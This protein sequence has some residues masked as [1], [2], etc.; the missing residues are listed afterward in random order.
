M[1]QA[2]RPVKIGIMQDDS[3]DQTEDAVE[4]AQF[5]RLSVNQCPALR[6]EQIDA[7]SVQREDH[8][9][10]DRIPH[11][12]PDRGRA[13]HTW[14]NFT[15]PEG[16]ALPAIKK[17]ECR[18]GRNGNQQNL[19]AKNHQPCRQRCDEISETGHDFSFASCRGLSAA[20]TSDGLSGL[21]LLA[22]LTRAPVFGFINGLADSW[23]PN[24]ASVY[25]YQLSVVQLKEAR[26]EHK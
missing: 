22:A 9:R 12:A 25:P 24:L 11:F 5:G 20:G 6:H 18:A 16:I 13:C 2:V 17:M 19:A 10:Q 26:N 8:R 23:T 7:K 21:K 3:G 4:P 1:H 15:S 14:L